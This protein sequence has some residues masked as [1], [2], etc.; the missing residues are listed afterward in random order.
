MKELTRLE[1][2][3]EDYAGAA[4][5]KGQFHVAREAYIAGYDQCMEDDC[6]VNMDEWQKRISDDYSN[7][8]E[9]YFNMKVELKETRQQISKILHPSKEER[10]DNY[11]KL[12]E[13]FREQVYY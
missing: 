4:W 2:F 9:K 5:K 3:A 8:K 12:K 13:E 7:L 6:E 1:R 10:L 11:L